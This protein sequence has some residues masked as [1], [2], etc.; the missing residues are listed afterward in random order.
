MGGRLFWVGVTLM[1]IWSWC[2]FQGEGDNH[3]KLA[4]G[5]GTNF[6]GDDSNFVF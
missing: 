2:K 4:S 3:D 1:E 5:Q 6:V